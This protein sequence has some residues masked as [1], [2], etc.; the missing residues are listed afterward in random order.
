MQRFGAHRQQFGNEQVNGKKLNDEGNIAVKLNM[1]GTEH[2]DH[3]MGRKPHQTD[4][5][6]QNRRGNHCE[7]GHS[8]SVEQTDEKRPRN[9]V[10]RRKR[11]HCLADFKTGGIFQKLK[12]AAD[13]A[14]LE[15]VGHVTGKPPDNS[16]H[17]HKHQKLQT[18]VFSFFV[19][20]SFSVG[21]ITDCL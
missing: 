13:I 19:R 3:G 4:N 1:R 21:L 9:G 16:R 17:D 7:K 8:Q 14:L 18:P 2:A 10:R 20:S 5:N 11:Q 12:A 15:I 6:P